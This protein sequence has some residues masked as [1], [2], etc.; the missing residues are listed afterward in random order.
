M[1]LAFEG[2]RFL[3]KSLLDTILSGFVRTR[4]L[5]VL[6]LGE[7]RRIINELHDTYTDRIVIWPFGG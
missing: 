5:M 7:G 6:N 1:L 3:A 4:Q 2:S